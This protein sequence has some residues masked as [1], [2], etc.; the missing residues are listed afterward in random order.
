MGPAPTAG[1]GARAGRTSPRVTYREPTAPADVG[2]DDREELHVPET[3]ARRQPVEGVVYEHDLLL[4]D[5]ADELA[6]VA[7]PFLQAGLDAGEAAVIATG[8]PAADV[9][10]EALGDQEGLVVLDQV[11]V[12]RARTPA[13]ITAFRELAAQRAGAGFPRIRVVG[14]T[15]FGRSPRDW[16][17]WERYEAVIN[18]AL[19]AQ[20]LWGLCVYDTGRLP[21]EV[22]EAGLRTH[23][24]LVTSSGRG[25][26]HDYQDPAEFLR[27]LPLLPEPLE[28]TEPL[29]AVD[30]V[31]DFI[32]LR[33]TVG[34][35]LAGLG[36][37][38]DLVE[39]LH[40]AIDEMTSNAV[41]H[42]GPPVQLRLWASSDRVVCRISDGGPGMDDP[43]A[44]YGPAHGSDLSRG[45]MGLWLARQLCDHVD[46]I[47]DGAGLT[48]R[49]AT[50]LH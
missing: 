23:P 13:A 30:D 18:D 47:D 27:S 32:G 38:P 24:H 20:P 11:G 43:F 12:Y 33:H 48:V 7:A 1:S 5:S 49:L 6:A 45:G 15:A 36:G 40:L 2:D 21:D 42:G 35:R 26:N 10:V 46:V 14:E 25:R 3:R 4:Y 22:V 39:D 19:R 50:S 9:L 29:L 44:G 31:S 8:G 17:E 34:E 41:R 37:S 28:E 16:R